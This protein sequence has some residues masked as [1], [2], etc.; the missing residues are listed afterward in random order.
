[1]SNVVET[2][3]TTT[4]LGLVIDLIRINQDASVQMHN[5][6]IVQKELLITLINNSN[7]FVFEVDSTSILVVEH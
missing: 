5:I 7:Q 4:S 3:L 1:M 6:A 2:I